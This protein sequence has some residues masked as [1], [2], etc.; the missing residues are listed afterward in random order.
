MHATY[1]VDEIVA[2]FTHER[3]LLYRCFIDTW[4]QL[5]PIQIV[6]AGINSGTL[7]QHYNPRR[8][9]ILLIDNDRNQH[10]LFREVV[11]RI[12]PSYKCV[13]ALS[14]ETAM[15]LLLEDDCILPDL[16][17]LDLKFRATEGK[18]MLR[19][20]KDSATLRE[21][22]V[23]IYTESTLEAD[24]ETTR[25]LGAIGYIIKDANLTNLAASIAAVIATT[26]QGQ[27]A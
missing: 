8:M 9:T 15:E 2:D 3:L 11:R 24:R 10:E 6:I 14:T 20:I 17:F 25:K 4:Q 23:C 27:D 7:Q 5:F 12:N 13:K 19:E 18:E 1:A 26:H 16:I 21:I 22:P